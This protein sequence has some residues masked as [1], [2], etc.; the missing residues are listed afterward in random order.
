MKR[1]VSIFLVVLVAFLGWYLARSP[2]NADIITQSPFD[3]Y[4]SA[5]L[6]KKPMLIMFT[7]DT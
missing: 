6:A 4:Q 3:V 7:S 2:V 5:L 1:S